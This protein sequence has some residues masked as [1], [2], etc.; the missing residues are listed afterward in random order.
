MKVSIGKRK[1]AQGREALY[2]SMSYNGKRHR[3][4]LGIVMD[5]PVSQE[6]RYCNRVKMQMALYLRAQR[7]ISLIRS[8]WKLPA[9]PEPIKLLDAWLAFENEYK[10]ADHTVVRA[11]GNKLRAYVGDSSVMLQGVNPS[12]CQEFYNYLRNDCGLR[13]HTPAGYFSKF[14]TFLS[15]PSMQKFF[16]VNPASN[17]RLSTDDALK[18]QTLTFE[19]LQVL[20]QTPCSQQQVKYAFLF[21][22]NTGLRWSDVSSLTLSN[23]NEKEK[24]ISF[25][26]RKVSG[27]SRAAALR[28]LLNANALTCMQKAWNSNG[29]IHNTLEER[30]F[31]LSSYNTCLRI[32]EAWVQ[33]AGIKKHITFHC[34]RHTF[35][36]NLIVRNVNLSTVAALAGHS[37]TRHTERYIHLSNPQFSQAINTLPQ[38]EI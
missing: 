34:A 23:Y 2:L 6:V 1:L 22:C 21:S 19:E 5:A 31:S 4:S 25:E 20:S 14:K 38:L 33:Q 29:R 24:S 12:F 8:A 26:Q 3:E 37:S 30:I 9:P 32:I 13:G 16:P 36:T 35:I 18:K 27:H 11:V 15:S 17:V 7:E 10:Q 28:L